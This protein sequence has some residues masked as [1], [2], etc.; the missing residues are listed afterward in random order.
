MQR[1][2]HRE[3]AFARAVQRQEMLV[4]I[5]RAVQAEAAVEP[6]AAASRQSSRAGD[7]G[8]IAEARGRFD[9]GLCHEVRHRAAGIAD[10]QIDRL[11]AGLDI[12][13]QSA[14]RA[15]GPGGN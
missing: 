10:G 4:R 12:A 3:Q 6:A 8:I 7:G 11:L 2:Q 9:Q 1:K 15:K 14:S 5:D 13:Q